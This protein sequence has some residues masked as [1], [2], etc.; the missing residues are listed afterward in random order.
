MDLW[1]ADSLAAGSARCVPSCTMTEPT[2]LPPSPDANWD[3]LALRP[4]GTI[5]ISV[6]SGSASSSER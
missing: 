1:I 4:T 2:A 3:S 5:E 6:A